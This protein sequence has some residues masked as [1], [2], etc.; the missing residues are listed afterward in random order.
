MSRLS[1]TVTSLF[2][3]YQVGKE[4]RDDVRLVMETQNGNQLV[5]LQIKLESKV[6]NDLTT[7]SVGMDE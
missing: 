1:E 3:L 2:T 6:Q 5:T 7:A 4:R